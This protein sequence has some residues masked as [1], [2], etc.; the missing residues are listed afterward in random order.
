MLT[1][2]RILKTGGVT[3]TK[4]KFGF[5]QFARETEAQGC[6]AA[7]PY[8]IVNGERLDVKPAR[9]GPGQAAAPPPAPGLGNNMKPGPSGYGGGEGGGMWGSRDNYG[10]GSRSHLPSSRDDPYYDPYYSS[11]KSR[12]SESQHYD[13]YYRD[14]YDHPG[15]GGGGSSGSDNYYRNEIDPRPPPTPYAESIEAQLKRMNLLVDLLFPPPDITPAR[16]LNDLA[17][18]HCL[19]AIFATTENEK[20]N[21]LTLNILHGEP[22]EHRNMPVEDALRLIQRNFEDYVKQTRMRNMRQV[23]PRDV[24]NLLLDLLE[25]RSLSMGDLDKLIKYLR[26]RQN[27]LVDDQIEQKREIAVLRKKLN[28]QCRLYQQSYLKTKFPFIFHII[29][30]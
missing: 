21:S 17:E 2:M 29:Y 11:G 19:Y 13:D 10:G 8:T 14:Y 7:G 26:E 27:A 1:Y 24:R 16:V 20:H 28:I 3:L 30:K 23:V 9:A 25:M 18:R 4:N 22:Q 5:I 6:L 15:G 12:D